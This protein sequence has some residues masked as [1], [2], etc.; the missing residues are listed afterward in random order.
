MLKRSIPWKENRHSSCGRVDK[1]KFCAKAC[2][3]SVQET[4][5]MLADS[6]TNCSFRNGSWHGMQLTAK[7][8]QMDFFF[9]VV[10]VAG[11]VIPS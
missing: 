4:K 9:V 5:G 11:L 8:N 2:E 3:F 6:A 7:Q 1:R 10:A